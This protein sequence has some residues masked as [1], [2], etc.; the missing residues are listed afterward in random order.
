MVLDA[1][2]TK[3]L[4]D[5]MNDPSGFINGAMPNISQIISGKDRL[6]QGNTTYNQK[7]EFILPNVEN[8]S[9][10]MR[11]A[12]CDKKFERMI[13]DMTTERM[14]GGSSLRKYRHSF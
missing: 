14:V 3:N 8:Y 4:W 6:R 10:F 2:A 12:Q 11:K 1:D 13:C 5:M 9:D 7:I